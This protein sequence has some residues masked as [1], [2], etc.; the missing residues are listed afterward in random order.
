[1]TL[2]LAGL[3]VHIKDL[4]PVDDVTF[5]LAKGRTLGIVGESGSGKTLTALSVIGLQPDTATIAGSIRLDDTHLSDLTERG[6]CEV[7]GTRIAMVFQNAQMALDPLMRVGAQLRE[8]LPRKI[9]N[10]RREA[11]A[12]LSKLVQMIRLRHPERVLEAYP[13]ELSGGERQRVLIAMALAGRPQV[14]IA[15]EPTTALDSVIRV[16]IL[17]LLRDLARER[18]H[19]LILITHDF[20]VVASLCDEVAV[21][22]GGRVME[23]GDTAQVL[24]TPQHR[25]TAALLTAIPTL[26]I[27]GP[28]EKA[29]RLSTVRGV[30]PP[31]GLFPTGCVFRDRC[32][33]A[34]DACLNRPERRIV[35]QRHVAC[36]HPVLADRVG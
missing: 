28:G 21:M 9:R 25:Y 8:C 33:F 1:M 4:A 14:I 18:G 34:D 13:H 6:W 31:L 19:S 7:R 26:E 36:W 27:R 12:E 5:T 17:R 30:V 10:R 2:A 3:R 22:Y 23:H 35:E 15:D 24:R 16:S 32:D 20:A 11:D 29:S